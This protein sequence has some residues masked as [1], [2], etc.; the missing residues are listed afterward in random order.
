[1]MACSL[2]REP[3][4]PTTM[5]PACGEVVLVMPS[6]LVG[7]MAGGNGP[8]PALD[9]TFGARRAGMRRPVGLRPRSRPRASGHGPFDTGFPHHPQGVRCGRR[10]GGTLYRTPEGVHPVVR[11]RTA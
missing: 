10:G 5:V 6:S 2:S 11:T 3:S 7:R 9:G 1:M 8:W 4:K